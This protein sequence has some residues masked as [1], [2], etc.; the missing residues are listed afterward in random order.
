M[1]MNRTSTEGRFDPGALCSFSLK[2]YKAHM[3]I[4]YLFAAFIALADHAARKRGW[5]PFGR[6]G[7]VT[8]DGSEVHFI[9]YE[10]QLA[11]AGN[12]TTNYFVGDLSPSAKRFK[13]NWAKLRA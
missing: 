2:C 11:V 8:P 12:D 6:T 3:S 7:W 13:R 5:H 10:E 9:C 1:C 4:E